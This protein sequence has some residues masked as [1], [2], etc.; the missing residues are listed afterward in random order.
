MLHS[1][2]ESGAEAVKK[3]HFDNQH[4][5]LDVALTLSQIPE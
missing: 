2:V 4:R 1:A 3:S 5:V